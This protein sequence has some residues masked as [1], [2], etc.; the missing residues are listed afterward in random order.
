M[1]L[2]GLFESKKIKLRFNA[3]ITLASCRMN[4]M[5]GL[6]SNAR[7]R[8]STSTLQLHIVLFNFKLTKMLEPG[9][10]CNINIMT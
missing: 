2:R 4:K 5:N 9:V 8:F 10:L 1:E 6:H 3:I 7:A